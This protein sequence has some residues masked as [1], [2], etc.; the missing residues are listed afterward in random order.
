M[1]QLIAP[2]PGMKFLTTRQIIELDDYLATAS[3][4]VQGHGAILSLVMDERGLLVRFCE[5]LPLTKIK[6]REA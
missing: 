1:G 3:T 6:L 5:P 2:A 4:V